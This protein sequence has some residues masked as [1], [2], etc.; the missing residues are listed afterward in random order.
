MKTFD[1]NFYLM[2]FLKKCVRK[3]HIAVIGAYVRELEIQ[4]L[5]KIN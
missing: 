1:F 4:S 2:H 3:D 5:L